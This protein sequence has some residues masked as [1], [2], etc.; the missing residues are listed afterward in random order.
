MPKKETS[1]L[2]WQI[3]F[4]ALTLVGFGVLMVYNASVA[5][6]LR[7]FNDKYYFVKQQA[8]WLGLGLVGMLVM[9]RI[10]YKNLYALSSTLLVVNIILLVLV[11]IPGVGSKVMGARRWLVLPGLTIQPSELMK[12]TQ[13][14]YL[15]SW[16]TGQKVSLLHFGGYIAFIAFLIML[17]PDMG[18]TLV[19]VFTSLA[20]YFLAQ[21]PMKNLLGIIAVGG[22]IGLVLILASPYR[23]ARLNTYFNPTSDPLGSSYHI[24]QV[25]MALGSGGTMGVGIG[26]SRQKY[27]Y[28]PESTTD[29]IFAVIGEETGFIGGVTLIGIFVYFIYLGFRVASSVKDKWASVLAGGIVSWFALQVILN[30]AS[31]VALTPLTGIPLP[32]VSYGGS[33]LITGLAGIGVL[34]GIARENKL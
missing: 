22:V 19:I 24:R 33:A 5:E 20:I 10:R 25:L 18:T 17:Q 31:M 27:E 6:A 30:L 13:V 7:D 29:S 1:R 15:S 16:L 11:L 34:I 28:L 8:K 23:R 26:K 12:F 3:F 9:S 32:L 4:L 2:A 14:V 21:Y